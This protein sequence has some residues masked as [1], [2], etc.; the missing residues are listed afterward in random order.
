VAANHQGWRRPGALLAAAGAAFIAE[1]VIYLVDG[2]PDEAGTFQDVFALVAALLL[3]AAVFELH[4]A[5]NGRDRLLGRIGAYVVVASL[6]L[7]AVTL[8]VALGGGGD[9]FRDTIFAITFFVMALGMILY[10]VALIRGDGLPTW[11]AVPF[12]LP[13][14]LLL[15]S[16]DYGV[17]VFGLIWAILGL[18]LAG[19]VGV[20][21]RAAPS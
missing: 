20:S 21:R 8:A 13:V 15:V 5:H 4:R 3:A 10:G 1:G 9:L 18:L 11:Y 7:Q 12:F 14:P 19:N 6:L 16:G 2:S 17:I